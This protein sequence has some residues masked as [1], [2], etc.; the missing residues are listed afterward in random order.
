LSAVAISLIGERDTGRAQVPSGRVELAILIASA[1][2]SMVTS[3]FALA[4]A[5][6]PYVLNLATPLVARAVYPR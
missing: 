4:Y 1:I 2:L 6:L 5:M 3:L